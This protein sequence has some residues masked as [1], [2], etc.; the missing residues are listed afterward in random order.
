LRV[1]SASFLTSFFCCGGKKKRE[2][3]KNSVTMDSPKRKTNYQRYPSGGT[4]RSTRYSRG[5]K[6]KHNNSDSESSVNMRTQLDEKETADKSPMIP[7]SSNQTSYQ[8]I[9]PKLR[10]YIGAQRPSKEPIQ[11]AEDL[12]EVLYKGRQSYCNLTVIN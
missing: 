5:V 1:A 3:V 12:T 2:K 8:E 6:R 4:P 9:F 10:E 7:N 11:G